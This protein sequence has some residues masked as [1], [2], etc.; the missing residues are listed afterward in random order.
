MATFRNSIGKGCKLVPRL[1][2]FAMV[3][4]G[5]LIACGRTDTGAPQDPSAPLFTPIPTLQPTA[6]IDPAVEAAGPQGKARFQVGDELVLTMSS[7]DAQRQFSVTVVEVFKPG[8][9]AN[10]LW[11]YQV[12]WPNGLI[13]VQEEI[14]SPKLK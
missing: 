8:D 10:R 1:V 9:G 13:R 11:E 14:L 3:V 6:T 2:V 4:I 12:R 5:L 7:G